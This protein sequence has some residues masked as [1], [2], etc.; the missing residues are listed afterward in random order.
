MNHLNKDIIAQ[1]LSEILTENPQF[2]CFTDHRQLNILAWKSKKATNA[3]ILKIG[4]KR[5]F[6]SPRVDRKGQEY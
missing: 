1:I 6:A 5:F 2:L 3:L 4:D